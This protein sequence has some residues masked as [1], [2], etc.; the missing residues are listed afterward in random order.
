MPRWMGARAAGWA[1][2]AASCSVR[3]WGD[4][5]LRPLGTRRGRQRTRANRPAPY[6]AVSIGRLSH[7]AELVE[8]R[9]RER[10]RR[11]RASCMRIWLT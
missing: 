4:V 6:R 7:F 5:A 8:D 10:P 3:V 2:G 9:R 11:R 1:V